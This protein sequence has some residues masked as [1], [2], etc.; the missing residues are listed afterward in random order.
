MLRARVERKGRADFEAER[1]AGRRKV[2]ARKS[3]QSWTCH[4]LLH[5]SFFSTNLFSFF[6][7]QRR[8]RHPVM[9]SESS[10]IFV[11]GLP[12]TMSE[13]DFK[14]HFGKYEVT[15]ARLFPQRRIGYVGYKSPEDAQKAVK[16][17]NRTFIR[18]SKIGVELAR[19][20]RC[21]LHLSILP[22]ANSPARS[23]RPLQGG[24]AS[25]HNTLWPWPSCLHTMQMPSPS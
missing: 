4:K 24:K 8:Y 22:S 7:L 11:R 3:R 1:V 17:F 14:T 15:D 19:P 13:A 12:P 25:R 16:Y 20:V 21:S 23:V 2:A 6:Y 18:M 9:E 10:R 5:H